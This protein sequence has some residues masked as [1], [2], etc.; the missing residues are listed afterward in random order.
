MMLIALTSDGYLYVI[1][2][3]AP[4]VSHRIQNS[5][6]HRPDHILLDCNRDLCDANYN[7]FSAEQNFKKG[8]ICNPG[9]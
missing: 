4:M 8:M 7:K 5:P 6:Q 1:T 2:A 9:P 3:Y